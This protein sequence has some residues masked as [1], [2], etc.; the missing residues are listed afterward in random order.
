[1]ATTPDRLAGA[2]VQNPAYRP[3]RHTHRPAGF[4]SLWSQSQSSRTGPVRVLVAEDDAAL[5]SVLV[6][7]LERAGYVVDNVADG[8]TALAYLRSYDYQAV[9]LDWRMPV[10]SGIEVVQSLR[11][12]HEGVPV[13]MLTARDMPN[14]RVLGL[15]E[16][17]DDYMVKPFDFP[18]LLARLRA[19]QRR[20]AATQPPRLAVGDLVYEPAT[21]MVTVSGA[22]VSLTHIELGILEVLMQRSPAIVTRQSIAVQVWQDEADAVGSN[23]IDVHVARLRSK[24]S[25]AHIR[26]ATHRG[27]GYGLVPA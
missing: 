17:A 20:P 16:G 27:V 4:S 2:G 13:L 25:A 24:L 11:H 1:M 6:R 22:V 9:V 10:M 7:G 3:A 23:T 14:D 26:I 5:R 12:M 8:A 15:D 21:R 18:E 19:L